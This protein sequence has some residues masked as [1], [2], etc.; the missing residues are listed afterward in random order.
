M[1]VGWSKFV[2]RSV[3]PQISACRIRRIPRIFLVLGG[4]RSHL[5][6]DFYPRAWFPTRTVLL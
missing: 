3:E 6:T 5:A 2:A 1:G 4:A